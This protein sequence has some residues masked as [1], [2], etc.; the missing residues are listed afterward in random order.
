M[1]EQALSIG[2]LQRAPQV[3]R[4]TGSSHPL[5]PF[6]SPWSVLVSV[7]CACA[8]VTALGSV[9]WFSITAPKLDRVEEPDRALELMVGRMMEAQEGLGRSP[10]WQ[11]WL[12]EWTM[13]DKREA[14]EQGIQWYR[15][16][17]ATTDDPR[18]KLRLAILLGESSRQDE[19]VAEAAGWLNQG[20]FTGLFEQLIVG[21]YGSQP[22]TSAQEVDLQAALAEAMPSGWFYNQLSA[23]LAQRGGDHAR[24][25]IVEEQNAGKADHVQQ[26]IRPLLVTEVICLLIGSVMLLGIVRLQGQRVDILRVHLPGVPPPWS[27][28]I[29]MAVIL[30]GGTLGVLTTVAFLS[31]PS[32]EQSV[33]SAF[34]IPLANI[35]LLILAYV[36]LLKPAGLTFWNGFGLR[37]K[38]A[39]P[40]RLACI[41]VAV[42]AAGLWGE[43]V[44]G[45]TAELFDLSNHWTEWFDPNLVWA[46]APKLT[47]SLLEYVVFAPICEEI[48]FR[49]LLYATLRRRL[50]F[51]PAAIIS[52]SIFALAHG[53]SLVGFISVFWSGFLWAWIYER[54]GSLIPGMVAHA[55]NN[56][57]VCLTV[58]AL[59]G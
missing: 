10:E 56:L 11:Q 9:V 57:L 47:V 3:D 58:M 14:Y 52:T 29:A 39:N 46:S 40:G 34:V 18:S 4:P 31:V 30:R 13:G 1:R 12:A 49:G 53:Y 15:E 43:W 35:P 51:F 20:L 55:M 25:A 54:T 24:L 33:L 7:V 19:A 45:R 42:I 37:M 41:I 59:L 48:A 22:L 27:G 36:H 16:L 2:Q 21:A 28:R 32:F 6:N 5:S 26:G 23:R 44:L 17:V 38:N 50:A 8:L